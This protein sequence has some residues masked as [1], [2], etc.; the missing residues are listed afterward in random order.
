VL[1][2]RMIVDFSLS[3]NTNI[4]VVGYRRLYINIKNKTGLTELLKEVEK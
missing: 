3:K 4:I 2:G 1:I